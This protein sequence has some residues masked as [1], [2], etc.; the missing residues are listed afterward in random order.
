VT[1]DYRAYCWGYNGGQVGDG[2]T[3]DRLKPVRVAGGGQFLQIETN[4][5]H[6]CAVGYTDRLPYCWGS[7]AEGELGE[8]TRNS[9]LTPIAAAGKLRMREV[10]TGYYHTCG[11]TTSNLAYCWGPNSDG[12]LG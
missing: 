3:I 12:Q 8:G 6:T 1:T 9:H 7:N 4:A 11:V 10:H 5:T 2:T